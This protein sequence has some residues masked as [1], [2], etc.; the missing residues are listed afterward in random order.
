MKDNK[1]FYYSYSPT[2][3][4][5]IQDIKAKYQ[6]DEDESLAQKIK[7]M[8][9]KT[10]SKGAIISVILGIA[11][12]LVFGFGLALALSFKSYYLG[13]IVGFLGLVGMTIVPFLDDK[14]KQHNRNKIA[15]K[16]VALCDEYLKNNK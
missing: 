16:I 10:D 1:T 8:D 12:T 5:E 15:K 3:K 2:E 7:A 6:P 14:I 9:K 4:Q 11:F 13:G